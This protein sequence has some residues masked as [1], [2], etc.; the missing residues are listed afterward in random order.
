MSFKAAADDLETV[1]CRELINVELIVME[2]R[3][4]AAELADQRERVAGQPCAFSQEDGD[5][6]ATEQMW[7][8]GRQRIRQVAERRQRMLDL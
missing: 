5:D 1:D 6:G 3:V 8:R 2:A 7:R 4:D